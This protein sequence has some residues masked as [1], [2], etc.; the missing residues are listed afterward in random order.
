MTLRRLVSATLIA[1]LL[2]AAAPITARAA[3]GPK[4]APSLRAS[5]DRAVT[6]AVAAQRALPAPKAVRAR[7]SAATGAQSSGGGSSKMVISL[8]GIAAGLA[9]TYYIVK[10]M[11][12]QTIVITGQ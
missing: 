1:S 5:F 2:L 8:I 4:P 12:K 9:G 10:E 3:E 6:D 11:N 7:A